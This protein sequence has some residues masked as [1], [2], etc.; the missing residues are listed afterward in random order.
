[1]RNDKA[2]EMTDQILQVLGEVGEEYLEE[3]EPACLHREW[4]APGHGEAGVKETQSAA[5]KAGNDVGAKGKQNSVERAEKLQRKRE[6]GAWLKWGALAACL[7]L[8]CGGIAY[9]QNLR[10]LPNQVEYGDDPNQMITD[11]G[12]PGD[13][14]GAE[15]PGPVETTE[16]DVSGSGAKE[17]EDPGESGDGRED[18]YAADGLLRIRLG[19]LNDGGMGFEGYTYHN[20]GELENSL[21]A[22][23]WRENWELFTLPV[24]R[25]GCFDPS[26]AGIPLGL[27]EG[28]MQER[29]EQAAKDLGVK[30]LETTPSW[31]PL[32]LEDGTETVLTKLTATTDR[33]GWELA[34]EADGEL[35]FR[36]EMDQEEGVPLFEKDFHSFSSGNTIAQEE[37][38][39]ALLFL[40]EKFSAFLRFQTPTC[41]IHFDRSFDHGIYRFCHVYDGTGAM[42]EQILNAAFQYGWFFVHSEDATGISGKILLRNQLSRAEKLGDYPIITAE[43]AKESLLQGEYL[44]SVPRELPG[45]DYVRAAELVYRDGRLE[46]YYMPYYR[47]YVEL[48]EEELSRE[49][50]EE[51]QEPL[52]P[53]G[54]YYV[55]ALPKEYLTNLTVYDGRFN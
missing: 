5:K 14:S 47:F 18:L 22:N 8:I 51:G 42:E 45:E 43:E 28:E 38:E 54:A 20:L 13:G 27:S 9:Y 52:I 26:G 33:E 7:C 36:F 10:I 31:A 55:P 37:L 16:S 30:I 6:T 2:Y 48:P 50:L 46:E 19:E 41:A 39:E 11:E 29:L 53:Y 4:D 1:M 17:Q 25:N 40:S 49:E 35:E 23:P 24:Y 3:A 12:N 44:T 21:K 15:P 32:Y 34:I